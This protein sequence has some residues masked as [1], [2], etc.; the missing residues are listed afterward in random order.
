MA[1]AKPPVA[2]GV[3]AVFPGGKL[4]DSFL[5]DQHAERLVQAAVGEART[6]ALTMVRGEEASWARLVDEL[7]TGSLF[8]PKRAVVV[9]NAEL[10]KGEGEEIVAYL[11]DPTPGVT[12]VLVATR[13]DRRKNPW[14]RIADR[15][16]VFE[17]EPP[18]GRALYAWVAAEARRQGVVLGDEAQQE[19]VDRLG[20]DLRRIA[21]EITKLAA[22]ASSGGGKG[23]LSAEDVAAVM[24]R[25]I[26]QPTYKLTDAVTERNLP[27]V[28]RLL[29]SQLEERGAEFWLLG[30]LHRAIRQLRTLRALRQ[31][32]AS[33][34][35]MMAALGLPPNVAFKLPKLEEAAARWQDGELRGALAA[36]ADADGH[37]KS[38]ADPR[39]TL[40]AA[41]VK[42]CGR[43]GDGVRPGRPGRSR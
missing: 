28:L 41:L 12:L 42:A 32:R 11:D 3:H 6:D 36:L 22:F 23:A 21:G 40:A 30:A 29:D 7:R 27:E 10:L 4:F 39:A 38:G 43:R 1:R 26:A 31:R 16:E 25:G 24:G 8:A 33:R 14:K 13:V 34:D 9:R 18:K 5:A 17:A 35:D 15:A 19:I 37:L 2:A 20:Q